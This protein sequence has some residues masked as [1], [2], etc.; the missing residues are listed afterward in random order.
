LPAVVVRVVNSRQG[1]FDKV[2]AAHRARGIE[3]GDAVD[4]IGRGVEDECVAAGA[5]GHG[6]G[7][8]AADD[9]IVAAQDR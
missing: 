9:A 7:A 2:A 8:L 1:Q 3:I 4:C 6:V 5:A